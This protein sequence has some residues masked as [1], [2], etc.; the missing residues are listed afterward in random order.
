MRLLLIDDHPLFRQGFRAMLEEARPDWVLATASRADEGEVAAADVDLDLILIDLS[1]PDADGF[2]TIERIGAIAPA[3]PR[4]VISARTDEAALRLAI[5]AG[6][7]GFIGKG[8][9]AEAVLSRLEGVAAGAGGFEVGAPESGLTLS[10]RQIEVLTLLA[11]GCPNKE[12][13]HRLGIAERTVRYHLTDVF[14]TLGVQSRVQAVLR[15]QA[16]GLLG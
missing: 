4:V 12:I 7:S 6:A 15:A 5:K 13:R 14:Q 11:E 2:E 9:D 1:L 3:T 10:P 8:D 16:L